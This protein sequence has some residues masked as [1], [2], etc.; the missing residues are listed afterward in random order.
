MTKYLISAACAAVLGVAAFAA[1]ASADPNVGFSVNVGGGGYHDGHH[2]YRGDRYS[3]RPGV[4]VY[5][6]RSSY[7]HCDERRIV[8]W[9]NGRK[10][11]RV[12]R[13]C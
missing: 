13:D 1:P 10:I 9:R 11:V 2:R 12:V 6:G 5:S 8:K 7:R 3:H 4:R